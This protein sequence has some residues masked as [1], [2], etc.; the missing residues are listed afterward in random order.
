[1]T[2]PRY[3]ALSGNLLVVRAVGLVGVGAVCMWGVWLFEL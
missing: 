3:R 2:P 1:M